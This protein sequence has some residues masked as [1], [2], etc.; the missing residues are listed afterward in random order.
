MRYMLDTDVCIYVAKKRPV[1]ILQ[2]FNSL[3]VDDACISVITY[4]ELRYGA[5]KSQH[6]SDNLQTLKPTVPTLGETRKI[7]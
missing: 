5:E 2:K 4:A 6:R 1:S 3:S 7:G